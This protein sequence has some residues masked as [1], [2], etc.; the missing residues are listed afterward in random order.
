MT[1]P[2]KFD[3]QEPPINYSAILEFKDTSPGIVEP[4]PELEKVRGSLKAI[5]L[6][7][8]RQEVIDYFNANGRTATMQ[9]FRIWRDSTLDDMI[10]DRAVQKEEEEKHPDTIWNQ[11]P[12]KP[13]NYKGGGRKI[14]KGSPVPPGWYVFRRGTIYD[15][16]RPASEVCG[17]KGGSKMLWLRCHREEVEDFYYEHGEAATKL[18]YELKGETLDA[19]LKGGRH[20]PIVNKFTR[21]DKLEMSME[22]YREDVKCLRSEVKE[23]REAFSQFQM[24]V[25]G[26]LTKRILL[27]LLQ[28]AID[29]NSE[30]SDD[31]E[32]MLFKGGDKKE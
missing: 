11:L 21:V 2:T 32:R 17:L 23:L 9:R 30:T 31:I 3:P 29:F 28:G 8:H 22:A 24:A 10:A 13:N 15:Y 7:E 4:L 18:R 19:I 6:K 12:G 26:Q 20:T 25:A 14:P 5:W 27:P 1:L 16:I